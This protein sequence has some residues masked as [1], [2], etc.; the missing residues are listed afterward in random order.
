MGRKAGVAPEDTREAVL[1][2]AMRTFAELGYAGASTRA[3]GAAAS[4]TLG[5][6]HHH[7]GSKGDLY[8]SC[9]LEADARL[10]RLIAEAFSAAGTGSA[11]DAVIAAVRGLRNPAYRTAFRLVAR[12]VWEDPEGA[13]EE[14][15]SAHGD[16]LDRGAVLLRQMR[17]SLTDLGARIRIQAAV[18]VLARFAI[19]PERERA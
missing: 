12:R 8:V 13:V 3:I 4:L 16:A 9:I 7:F 15:L 2:A 17:P 5:A 14:R 19:A 10:R 18:Y 1:E 11:E 6:V